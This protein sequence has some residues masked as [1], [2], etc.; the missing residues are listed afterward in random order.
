MAI[1]LKTDAVGIDY[2]INL[3]INRLNE[4]LNVNK[5][6]AVDIFHKIYRTDKRNSVIPE[7]FKSGKEYREI[8]INDKVN[9]EI[10]FLVYP[11][12]DGSSGSFVV[13]MDIIFSLNLDKIDNGS[14]QREDEKA[15][16]V[17]QNIVSKYT[18]I[19]EVKTTLREVFH[20]FD[21]KRI[22]YKDMQP[23]L[24][25]SFKIEIIYKNK[26]NGL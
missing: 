25:F 7:A 16:M 5:D 24:N 20:G 17:A 1:Y 13:P 9:G 19:L 14:L 23:F 8:F 21:T 4:S 11:I 10:G 2:K 26:C 15:I 6:W 22:I 3:W 12:R 18:D